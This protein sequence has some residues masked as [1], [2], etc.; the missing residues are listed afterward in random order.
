MTRQNF[1][2][3]KMYCVNC[4]NEGISIPRRINKSKEPG[5]LKKMY[6]I[7]CKKECN[8]VEIRPIN[9]DYNYEDFLLEI[10]YGNFD[11]EGNRKEPY[12]IFRGN[13]KK[14]GVI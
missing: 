12:R 1:S 4:H 9:N 3:S 2:V 10:K 14:A 13:L 7:H 8:H 5:H 6:C 11:S